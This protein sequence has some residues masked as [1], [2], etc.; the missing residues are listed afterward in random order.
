[1]K[2]FHLN[3]TFRLTAFFGFHAQ[4]PAPHNHRV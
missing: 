2:R 1:V 4:R 3:V